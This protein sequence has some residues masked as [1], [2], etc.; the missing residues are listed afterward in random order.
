MTRRGAAGLQGGARITGA[1]WESRKELL[2]KVDFGPL[3]L[4]RFTAAHAQ[5]GFTAVTALKQ[6]ELLQ[7]QLLPS[8][9]LARPE[10]AV[11]V[12]HIFH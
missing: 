2:N 6:P 7:D 4:L 10:P 5:T 12:W 8:A 11:S 9:R 1:L 3:K